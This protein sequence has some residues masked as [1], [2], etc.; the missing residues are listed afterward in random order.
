MMSLTTGILHNLYSKSEY[1]GRR[2][3]VARRLRNINTEMNDIRTH[4]VSEKW[5]RRDAMID[6]LENAHAIPDVQGTMIFVVTESM[7]DALER[8]ERDDDI[9]NLG[10]ETYIMLGNPLL[11]R[12]Y[13][14]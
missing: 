9:R 5:G 10:A 2:S 14:A 4:D 7:C 3:R 13:D 8:G 1:A 11:A 12:M 6:V